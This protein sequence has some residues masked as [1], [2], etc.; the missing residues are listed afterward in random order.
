[1]LTVETIGRIR[2]EH[3]VKGKTIK[4]IARDLKISRNTVRKIFRSNETSFVYERLSRGRSSRAG[5][6][7]SIACLRP[8]QISPHA[9]G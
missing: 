9:S 7:I 4:E 2:R 6:P 1:M 3:F 8:I 5:V